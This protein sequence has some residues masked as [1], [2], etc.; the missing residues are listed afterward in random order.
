M[1]DGTALLN[2][3]EYQAFRMQFTD[4]NYRHNNVITSSFRKPFSDEAYKIAELAEEE[5][6]E[7]FDLNFTHV[8]RLLNKI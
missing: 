2:K 3:D 8:F 6:N 4:A 7:Y 1:H 5:C